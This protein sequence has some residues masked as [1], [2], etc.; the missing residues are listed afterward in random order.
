M[1]LTF[2][3]PLHKQR[4]QFVVDFVKRNKPKKVANVF[5]KNTFFKTLALKQE[6][7][8]A[9]FDYTKANYVSK[10]FHQTN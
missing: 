2:S 3:P 7:R 9:T 10:H 1:D 8:L 5:V 6:F 4:R